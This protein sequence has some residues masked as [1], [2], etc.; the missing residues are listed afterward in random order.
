MKLTKLL[1]SGVIALAMSLGVTAGSIYVTVS[2]AT[3]NH[4]PG[5]DQAAEPVA[6]STE[7][8][9]TSVTSGTAAADSDVPLTADGSLTASISTISVPSGELVPAAGVN[10]SLFSAN[11]TSIATTTDADGFCAFGDLSPGVY[12]IEAGGSQGR[13]SYGLRAVASDFE[14]ARTSAEAK[15]LPVSLNMQVSTEAALTPARDAGA[16]SDIIDSTAVAAVQPATAG[17]SATEA[18]EASYTARN[19][20]AG[21]AFSHAPVQLSADGSLEGQLH[22]LDPNTG[23]I[24]PVR[25]LTVSFI[26]DNSVVGTTT[27]RPDG[28][29]VQWNLMPGI[30]SVIAAGSDG[31]G[32]IGVQVVGDL[33]AAE[34][35][36]QPIP[37]AI[38]A[39][40][41]FSL[42]L[43]Q[44]SSG[45]GGGGSSP[46]DPGS[47]EPVGGI[48]GAP[49]GGVGGGGG[50]P[51]GSGW[52]EIL[53]AAG[54]ALGAAA[55]AKDDDSGVS[56]PEL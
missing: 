45:N 27:V 43:A 13:L 52:G 1:P 28:S 50:V 44:G 29:F 20:G 36:S 4:A 12:T 55:L 42:G 10:V 15:Y 40:S 7:M 48:P 51:G 33:A 17:P 41:S 14:L 16:L 53:G 24:L 8:V 39:A 25:D 19:S 21:S 32:Y 46:D 47:S 34:A 22:L 9:E 18:I 30:Y 26:S 2:T 56:S 3:A 23:D 5:A 11:G 35:I 31:V 6:A 38:R 37:T 49:G 54:I